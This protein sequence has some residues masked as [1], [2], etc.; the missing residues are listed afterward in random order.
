MIKRDCI[1]AQVEVCQFD[2]T[3]P[4]LI[5]E[6]HFGV[7]Q[8]NAIDRQPQVT[9]MLI[10]STIS[11][12]GLHLNASLCSGNPV[13]IAL[14]ITHQIQLQAVHQNA[15]ELDRTAEQRGNI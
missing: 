1:G 8:A 3:C 2:F 13:L 15:I 14:G 4:N 6:A 12:L 10:P 7:A 5:F 11:I 9:A